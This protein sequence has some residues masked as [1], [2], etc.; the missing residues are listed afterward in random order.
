MSEVEEAL[1]AAPPPRPANPWPGLAIDVLLA[2]A[3]IFIVSTL[4]ITPILLI[5]L[6]RQPPGAAADA[7][8]LMQAALPQV[9][10]AAIAAM[11][12]V[13]LLVWWLRGRR[14]QTPAPRL[15]LGQASALALL[16]GLVVQ[17][18]ALGLFNGL[19]ALAGDGPATPS[20]AA[21]ILALQEAAP[22]LNW[23]MVVVVAPLGEELLF[24]RVLLHRF[25]V[26]GRGLLGLV[27]SSLLFAATHEVGQGGNQS[28]LQWLGLM[29]VY[30][31]MGMGFGAVYLRTGRLS[32]AFLAHAACN[33]TAMALMAFSGG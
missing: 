1:V 20:N 10:V 24:R 25:M 6:G 31:G 23:L 2:V 4:L 28:L 32:S 13:G 11:L 5:E 27:V 8:A 21:P 15:P 18:I 16:A 14:L 12:V 9:T 33:A 7:D 30:T 29:A 3:G 26:A 22:V 17:A 19:Q